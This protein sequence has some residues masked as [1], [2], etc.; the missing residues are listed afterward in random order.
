MIKEHVQSMEDL[1]RRRRDFTTDQ[2]Q[3]LQE[4]LRTQMNKVCGN[5]REMYSITFIWSVTRMIYAK[6][7]KIIGK[8]CLET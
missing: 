6:K 2:T 5:N 8:P 7:I 1:H 3:K 4:K